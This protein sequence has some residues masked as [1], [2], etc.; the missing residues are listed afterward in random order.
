MIVQINS[1][2]LKRLEEEGKETGLSPR[3]LEFHRRILSIQSAARQPIGSV[4]P[5]LDKKMVD[6]CIESG[7]PLIRPDE[8]NL[9]WSLLKDTFAQIAATFAD[10]PDL[11]GKFCGKLKEPESLSVLREL[12]K[13]QSDVA[14]SPDASTVENTNEHLLTRAI[15]FATLKPFLVAHSKTLLGFVNQKRCRRGYCPIC[16]GRADFAFLDREHGARWLVCWWCDAEW[17]FQRLQCP[18]C[19]NCNQDSL[20]Y[21]TDEKGVYRFYVCERC[22]TYIKAVDLR[23]VNEKVSLPLER[24]LTLDMDVQAQEKGY[25]PGYL[26]VCW[27]SHLESS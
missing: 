18:Y 23:H 4:G 21:F 27:H 2:T 3:L 16:G 24:A 13:A 14:S 20:A 8:L 10:Y 5:A 15:I 22:R 1:E 7:I 9:D 11:F 17:L 26:D 25:R 6:D 12:I 19:N